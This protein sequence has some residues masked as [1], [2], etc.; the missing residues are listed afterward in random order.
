MKKFVAILLFMSFLFTLFTGTGQAAS[1]TVTPKLYLDNNLLTPAVGPELVNNKYTVVPIRVISENIGAKVN[2][3]QTNKTVTIYSGNDTVFLK[4][5]DI[6]AFVN[7][8]GL[9]MDT[10][11]IVK[12]GTTLV[13]L[14]FV[15]ESLGLKVDWDNTTKTVYLKSPE[16]AE[17]PP[18]TETTDPG[19]SGEETAG[20]LTSITYD[21]NGGVIVTYDGQAV[22]SKPVFL[23]NPKRL[24]FD[25]PNAGFSDSFEPAFP[26]SAAIGQ[27]SVTGHPALAQIRYSLYSLAP[28]TVRVVLDL[29]ADTTYTV[30]ESSG[31]YLIQLGADGGTPTN[32]GTVPGTDPG[33]GNSD[34]SNPVPGKK[35]TVVIDAGHGGTDPGAQSI[36]S[37]KW[38]KETN[39]SIALKVKALLDKEPLI[40]AQMT[41]STD[42]FVE[43]DERV[44]IAQKLKADLFLSIH[45]NSSSPSASGTETYYTRANSKTLAETV[46]K[47]L[48]KGTGLKDRGVKTANYRV[49][50]ATTMP[51]IL[52]ETGFVTNSNDAA[53]LFDPAKQQ[54]IAQ[55]IVQGI[56]AYLKIS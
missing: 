42:V 26:S 20:S 30:T 55:S 11:A 54:V 10:P 48:I 17:T 15:G 13:P 18:P 6:Q 32:P 5:N 35:Y 12:S 50:K 56:K 3:D 2:W 4:I 34:G 52:M 46:H 16:P 51:A 43:L 29:T 53:I 41:R 37:G 28:S 40:N 33:T 23:D 8:K 9:Q 39:L 27:I 44:N 21:G 31:Q 45:A 7:D 14:R 36:L 25:F 1:A 47:Y 24:V 38:E 22:M 19:N 49:T